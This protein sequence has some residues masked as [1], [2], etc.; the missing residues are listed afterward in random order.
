MVRLPSTLLEPAEAALIAYIVNLLPC[1]VFWMIFSDEFPCVSVTVSDV[2]ALNA[3]S[4]LKYRGADLKL[5]M[6]WSVQY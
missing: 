3:R 4:Q 5:E 1:M 6:A 2:Y